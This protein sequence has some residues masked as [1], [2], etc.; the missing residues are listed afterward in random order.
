MENQNALALA[1]QRELTP[2]IWT[3]ISQMAPVMYKSR[4]FGVTSPEAAAAIMLKG[5]ELGLSITASFE[6]VQ[7]VQGRPGLSPRGAMAL[8]LN[9]P[10][11]KA[12]KITRLTDPSGNY[13][14]HDCYMQRDNGFE[15]S[16]TFTMEDAKRAGLIKPG[17]GWTSYPENMAQWRAIGFCADVVAPDIVAGMTNIMKMPE[18]YGVALSDHGDIIDVTVTTSETQ[19]EA[20]PVTTAPVDFA[21]VPAPDPVVTSL[22]ELVNQYGAE[23]VMI[24]N[25][26]R[27]PGTDEELSAVAA[28]LVA[29]VG[30]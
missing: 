13:I 23:A 16:I 4:L 5:F 8:L 17:S 11:I 26:G 21:P 25:M 18:A 19:L 14:G 3:M 24:A 9:S 15:Y 1:P 20:Q 7:V 22:E 27:I 6:L 12:I 28:K 29:Q 30:S 10:K 2:A